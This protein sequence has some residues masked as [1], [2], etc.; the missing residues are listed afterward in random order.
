MTLDYQ[1][2]DRC[3]V[4]GHLTK[5][6]QPDPN[7]F[8]FEGGRKYLEVLENS[9]V[10]N[11][12]ALLT[13]FQPY[14]CRSCGAHY[15]EPWL[16]LKQQNR[17]FSLRH[18]IHNVGWRN[19][20]EKF[21]FNSNPSTGLPPSELLAL[22]KTRIPEIRT[23]AEFG[24]PFQGLLLNL[25]DFTNVDESFSSGREFNSMAYKNYKR[26]LTPARIFMR[27]ATMA[28]QI[29]LQLTKV[30]RLKHKIRKRYRPQI[31]HSNS[32]T[33]Y[34]VPLHSTAFWGQNCSMYG[35][36]C[37]ATAIKS[38]SCTEIS[39][40]QF[41]DIGGSK[42]FDLVGLFNILDHQSN[43][44]ELLRTCASRS[45]A[46]ICMGHAPPYGRQHHFGLSDSFFGQIEKQ[47]GNCEVKK[48]PIEDNSS[49]L[50]VIYSTLK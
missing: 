49:L 30:R 17:V 27:S 13:E 47:I 42:P 32:I 8:D 38:L 31:Q 6:N 15:L 11:L 50:Y 44:V 7:S 39:L 28:K 4:C 2:I 22:I 10:T 41:V 21:E 40:Q 20:Q 45:K 1:V 26:F 48:I 16:S 37:T 24:C 25:A 29:S 14:L 36:S 23:Y 12:D 5:H 46:I 19:F 9:D 18:S 43:P 33:R 3:P 34:F 35:D